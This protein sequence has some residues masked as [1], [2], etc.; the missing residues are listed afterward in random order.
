M[1]IKVEGYQASLLQLLPVVLQNFQQGR[2]HYDLMARLIEPL[3]EA[4]LRD[5]A[6]YFSNLHVS[7]PA[8][9]LNATGVPAVG[10]EI[11]L[12]AMERGKHLVM[13]NVEADVTIGSYLKHEADKRKNIPTA[14]FQSVV[15]REHQQPVQV[16]YERGAPAG[17]LQP[18]RNARNL[19][20][21]YNY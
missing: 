8:P 2:R 11:G 18:E 5:M 15:Q 6:Q 1:T 13:M 19:Q 17:P 16:T 9:A 3:P 20:R 21:S 10:A 12:Q 4:Y 14:E 7:Y